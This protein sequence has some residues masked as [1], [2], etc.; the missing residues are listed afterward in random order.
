MATSFVHPFKIWASIS[1]SFNGE[2]TSSPHLANSAFTREHAFEH[3]TTLACP[4]PS[5]Q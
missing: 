5:Y 1:M 4:L 2:G 3:T